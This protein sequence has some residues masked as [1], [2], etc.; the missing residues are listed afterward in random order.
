[1]HC[2]WAV[3]NDFAHATE[4]WELS[5]YQLCRHWRHRRLSLWQPAVPPMTKKLSSWQLSVFSDNVT[6]TTLYPWQ[7]HLNTSAHTL[8]H[9]NLCTSTSRQRHESTHT[10]LCWNNKSY[11]QVTIGWVTLI[12]QSLQDP[13]ANTAILMQ[14]ST[15]WKKQ[16]SFYSKQIFVTPVLKSWWRIFFFNSSISIHEIYTDSQNIGKKLHKKYTTEHCLYYFLIK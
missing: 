16:P 9:G 6:T 10:L 8:T 3:F 1:M 5:W 13:A 14:N 7:Q 11:V 4:N 2:A 15:Y 12:I